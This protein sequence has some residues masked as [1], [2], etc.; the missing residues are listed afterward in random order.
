[1]IRI[2]IQ[3]LKD[4][5]LEKIPEKGYEGIEKNDLND[6]Q[7]KFLMSNQWNESPNVLETT[8]KHHILNSQTLVPYNCADL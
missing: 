6:P 7:V 2:M 1:M 5:R 4:V 8:F 3:L